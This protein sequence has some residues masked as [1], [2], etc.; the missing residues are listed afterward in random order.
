[1][2]ETFRLGRIA[3]IE[4]GIN[5][6]WL[7]VFALMLWSLAAGVFPNE[8]PGLANQT[9]LTMAIAAAFLFFASLLLHELGH[10]VTAQRQGMTIDGITLWLF[11][12]VAKFRGMFPSASI[13][14]RI[15]IAGP[16]VSIALGGLFVL[17]AW[18]INLGEA[19]DAVLLWLGYIN[20]V[21]AAFNMLPAQPLDG[22]RV[23]H[24]FLWARS[25]DLIVATRRAAKAGE[26]LGYAMIFGGV[27][28]FVTLG[29]FGGAWIA[30]LG[31]FLLTAARSEAQAIFMRQ[32]L[33]DLRAADLM[34]PDPVTVDPA[35]SLGQFMDDVARHTRFT[36]YPVVGRDGEVLGLLTFRAVAATART[37]WDDQHVA[38]QMIALNALVVVDPG[39]TAADVFERMAGS[40]VSR[41]L[42]I[43]RDRLVGL[44]SITD[45]IRA[46]EI[47]NQFSPRR[48][49]HHALE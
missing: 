3:G 20:L 45:L 7:I 33:G 36:T 12:G 47:G 37:T 14:F 26:A 43:D 23:L 49:V 5:W 46:V 11:G 17:S 40:P 34:T 19:V 44:L 9:Y 18:A 24:A 15:A 2:K 32:A 38:D 35:L 1:M 42:V 21:L 39:E 10:A 30:F 31:W 8:N 27:L 41:A 16:L 48:P 25:G 13:E 29:A 22:G 6:S 28:A 4:I